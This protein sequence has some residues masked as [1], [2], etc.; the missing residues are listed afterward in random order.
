MWF[1]SYDKLNAQGFVLFLWLF[2][3]HL[4]YNKLSVKP[5]TI[6]IHKFPK[7]RIDPIENIFHRESIN[8]S[9]GST[10][11]LIDKPDSKA[12]M[13][14]KMHFR[15]SNDLFGQRGP[16]SKKPKEHL[17]ILKPMKGR[18][19]S[20]WVYVYEYVLYKEYIA[21]LNRR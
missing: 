10:K 17:S 6:Y 4:F 9:I 19:K 21:E 12:L 2:L 5:H 18:K 1:Q 7:N 14:I 8:N 16:F 3:P 15:C 11:E 20:G 13:P